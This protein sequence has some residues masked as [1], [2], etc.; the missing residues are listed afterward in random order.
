MLVFGWWEEPG[1]NPRRYKENVQIQTQ[2]LPNVRQHCVLTTAPPRH[3]N[4]GELEVFCVRCCL[5]F[6]YSDEL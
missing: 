6:V 4:V 3:V 1:E 2:D 5:G